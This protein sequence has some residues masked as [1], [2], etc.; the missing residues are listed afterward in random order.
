[1]K[2]CS[3][4]AAGLVVAL[5]LPA[6]AASVTCS[7]RPGSMSDP[8]G[9]AYQP[10]NPDIVCASA[11]VANGQLILTEAF[12]AGFNVG[13]TSASF[14]LDIDQNAATGATDSR[15]PGLGIDFVAQFGGTD[16]GTGLWLWNSTSGWSVLNIDL[17][18]FDDGYTM[19]IPLALL[20]SDGAVN[21]AGLTTTRVGVNATTGVQDY[22]AV[23]S[24]ATL[25]VP[26]PASSALAL[27]ALGALAAVRRR[28]R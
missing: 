12:G 11:Q 22:T 28:V 2:S 18:I 4:A 6:H 8:I 16:F 13:T 21:F 17:Q 20:G 23:G 7:S 10:G 1:M 25:D 5:G 24:A 26:E 14:Y 9:D 19:S 27:A 15:T 3:L